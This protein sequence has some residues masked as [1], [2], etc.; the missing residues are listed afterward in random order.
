MLVTLGILVLAKTSEEN[1][2]NFSKEASW[3]TYDECHLKY[4]VQLLTNLCLKY[5][6]SLVNRF[7]ALSFSFVI[8]Y[9]NKRRMVCCAYEALS[10]EY[11]LVDKDKFC[12]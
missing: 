6:S 12:P 8:R 2:G 4:C 11:W 7:P 1:G 3:G 10:Q 9:F 5:N